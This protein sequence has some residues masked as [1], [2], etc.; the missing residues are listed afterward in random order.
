[1]THPPHE[2]IEP[3]HDNDLDRRHE[4]DPRLPSTNQPLNAEPRPRFTPI[5]GVVAMVVVVLLVFAVITLLRYN[6]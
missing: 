3:R 6:S 5:L 4:V 1:M 2:P